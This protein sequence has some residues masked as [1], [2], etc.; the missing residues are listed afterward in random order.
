[1]CG[2]GRRSA[3]RRQSCHR[4]SFSLELPMPSKPAL[5]APAKIAWIVSLIVAVGVGVRIGGQQ[6]PPAAPG[7]AA[8]S[9]PLLAPPVLPLEDSY[10]QWPLPVSAPAYRTIDGK[11]L[12]T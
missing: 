1:M 7:A 2:S 3:S 9:R 4:G 6:T 12:K 5:R 11:H 8:A 10:L